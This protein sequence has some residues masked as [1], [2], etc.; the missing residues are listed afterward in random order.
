M[1]TR[2]NS[3]FGHFS[4]FVTEILV[5]DAKL[6]MIEQAFFVYSLHLPKTE[7]TL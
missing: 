6:V 5:G 1:R 4:K 3:I 7:I 2:K